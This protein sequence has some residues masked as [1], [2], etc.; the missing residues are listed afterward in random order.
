MSFKFIFDGIG[1]GVFEIGEVL[2]CI[3]DVQDEIFGFVRYV[4]DVD[5]FIFENEVF[6]GKW[7]FCKQEVNIVFNQQVFFCV[8]Y[9]Y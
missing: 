7:M 4:F 5:S 9:L 8:F 6:Y 2:R 3:F 1:V